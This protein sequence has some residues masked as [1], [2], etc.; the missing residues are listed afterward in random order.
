MVPY[1]Y[2]I[3]FYNIAVGRTHCCYF[4]PYF[5]KK[6]IS[7]S[8]LH[9]SIIYEQKDEVVCCCLNCRQKIIST[10]NYMEE[11]NDFFDDLKIN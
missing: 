4:C 2:K 1:I 7:G 11:P 3:F 9:E 8:V 10:A 6:N 5:R